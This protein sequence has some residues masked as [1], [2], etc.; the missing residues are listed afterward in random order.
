MSTHPSGGTTVRRGFTVI[1]LLVVISIIAILTSVITAFVFSAGDRRRGANT[2][3]TIQTVNKALQHHWSQVI[4]DAKK[5]D[6]S[7]ATFAQLQILS[8]QTK[9][10]DPS[11]ERAR[12]IWI[13]LRLMEAFPQAYAEVNGTAAPPQNPVYTALTT[14][15]P[16]NRR[17]NNGYKK[18]LNNGTLKQANDPSSESS[19]CLLMA[20]QVNRGGFS[21]SADSLGSAAF[22][23]DGDGLKEIVDGWTQLGGA[24][25]STYPSDPAHVCTGK[26]ETLRFYRFTW[27]PAIQALSPNT[28][29]TPDPIDNRGLLLNPNWYLSYGSA[30]VQATQCAITGNPA[31]PSASPYYIIPVIVS[32]GSDNYFGLQ[33]DTNAATLGQLLYTGPAIDDNIY[34]YN[35]RNQ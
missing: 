7:D 29:S 31:N 25:P 8:G 14:Y 11:L 13:K 5:E 27:S 35:L 28:S 20:L 24:P 16:P 2:Q 3:V 32:S 34:S 17:H 21:L 22:D 19:A 4:A 33:Q 30:Y 6:I 23:T 10:L 26:P 15:I 18:T 1:E 12:V 9:G